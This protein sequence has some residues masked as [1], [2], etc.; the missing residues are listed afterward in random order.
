MK[1]F[2]RG[3]DSVDIQ[4]ENKDERS[5]L[6]TIIDRC[7]YVY[8]PEITTWTSGVAIVGKCR[9]KNDHKGDS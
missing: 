4:A 6:K 5:Y 2:L 9:D 8:D 1:L 7:I 3:N